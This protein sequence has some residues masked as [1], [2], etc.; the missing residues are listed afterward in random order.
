MGRY[1]A[2]MG[3]EARKSSQEDFIYDRIQ[4][5][6]ATNAFG[7]GIDK[8]N[9]RYVLHYNMP[10]VWKIIIRK[11]EE[12]DGIRSRQN[13]SFTIRLRTSLSISFCWKARKTME[14]TQ[15]KRCRISRCRIGSGFRR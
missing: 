6:I 15:R 3:N 9:V 4:V 5:M 1:H 7:M 10:Q 8:S 14:N 13:A 11:R 12:P 2:G